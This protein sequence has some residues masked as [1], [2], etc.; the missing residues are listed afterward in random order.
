MN[1]FKRHKENP[2]LEPDPAN[3]WEREGSFNGCPAPG[4]LKTHFLY[5]AVSAPREFNGVVREVSTIGYATST[6]GVHFK[7]RRQL[8]VPEEAWEKFGCEDPRVTKLNGKYYIFYTALSTYPFSPEGIRIGVA[9]TEDF[10][11][12]EKHP[13][14]TFNAKAMAL[15]P[16]CV[17]GKMAAMLTVHTDM[18]PAKIALALFDREED[19][20][21]PAFWHKWYAKLDDHVIGLQRSPVDHFEVGAPPLETPHGWLMFYSY[22]QN[23][24]TPPAIF[25]IEA[26]LLDLKDPRKVLASIKEPLLTPEE[27][28]ER[29]GKVP[30]IVF[31]S[32]AL[33]KK[34]RVYLYY[35]AADTRSA[36][37][38]G[39]TKEI[40]KA[41]RGPHARVAELK[42]Y[43]GNPVLKPDR[44]HPW[45]AKAVF[46]PAALSL[47]GNIHLLYRAMS[48]DNTSVFGY[49][50]TKDGFTFYER[51]PEPVYVPRAAF[52]MKRIPGG[53]SGCEDP[54]I[55]KIGNTLF[56]CYT[57][58]NGVEEPRVAMSSISADDFLAK[59]W[60][61]SE[62]VLISPP[63]VSDK[64]AAF[65]PKRFDGKFAILHR[66]GDSIW[67]DFSADLKFGTNRWLDGEVLMRPRA[68]ERDS[69]KIGIAGPPIETDA[70]WL[71]LYHG[72]SRRGDHHYDL[73]AALLDRENP[74]IVL[75]RTKETIFEPEAPYEREGLVPNVVF[76]C[77][78][79][80]LGDELF[81]YYGAADTVL[82]VATVKLSAL[83]G[84][85]LAEGREG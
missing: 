27:E 4:F 28:Y 60:H 82:G 48:E 76:P 66:L 49:A 32:G 58:Y 3:A 33:E 56:L 74:K 26:A 59:R 55:T 43:S 57:A 85:L 75:A 25:G 5:R 44:S 72:I 81:V 83:I 18:P 23:Y 40:L 53:N 80:P 77:G 63:G 51:M 68:G 9:V 15:F 6:D 2:I 73:R 11:R 37:A 39:N 79:A 24:F 50:R 21:S 52:E 62:P 38:V 54:R 70:G 78:L 8:I 10:K 84:K 13:V 19:L 14:T 41:M 71:L 35:G 1:L 36:L 20:W 31:P 7:N 22:I 17:M 29:F 69:R 30:N 16:Q 46:N 42:R 67:I 45:E 61:W 12:F 47:G 34:G 64:D 65:F